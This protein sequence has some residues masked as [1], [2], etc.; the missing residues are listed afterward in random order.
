MREQ[1]WGSGGF[2]GGPGGCWAE[3]GQEWLGA[4]RPWGLAVLPSLVLVPLHTTP[5]AVETE[6]NA[7][8]HVFLDA[9]QRWQSEVGLG[10]LYG[11]EGTGWPAGQARLLLPS[12]GRDPAWGLQR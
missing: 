9:S 4:L 6:L 7:L 5:K 12:P 8:Y 10:Q 2:Y 1:E 3:E 11:R